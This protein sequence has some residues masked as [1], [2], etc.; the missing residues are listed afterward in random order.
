I[1]DVEGESL[2]LA[3]SGPLQD[4]RFR[5]EREAHREEQIVVR[6]DGDEIRLSTRPNRALDESAKSFFER[7]WQ[8][9]LTGRI[10]DLGA[11]K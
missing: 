3:R 4:Y 8:A 1:C 5:K 10:Y 9:W 11:D 7:D 6:I 2:P